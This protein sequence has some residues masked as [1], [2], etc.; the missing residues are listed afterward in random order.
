MDI[1]SFVNMKYFCDAVRLNSITAAAKNNFV[2][3]SAISQG[4]KKLEISLGCAL[5]SGHPNRFRLTPEGQRA[6]ESMFNI[7]KQTL[8]FQ[9]GFQEI[10]EEAIGD[11]E[12]ICMF[13]FAYTVIPSYLKRFQSS[14]PSTLVNLQYS[15]NP[16]EIK[17]LVMA[18]AVDFGILP[19]FDYNESDTSR[20]EKRIIYKT[21]TELFVSGKVREEKQKELKFIITEDLEKAVLFEQ[22][23]E[24]KYGKKPAI[25]LKLPSWVLA[26]RLASEGLG[27]AYLPSFIACQEFYDLQPYK[28]DIKLPAIEAFAIYPRGMKLRKS[29]ETF[30][31][32]FQDSQKLYPT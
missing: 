12:F 18:G 17:R 11:L 21:K 10:R 1:L 2:T 7:L 14:F 3:Q 32:Y 23:Y 16:H 29:S 26:A 30:L 20:F 4:I 6:F 27:I 28:T 15:G 13:S 22:I 19:S 24:K 9:K 8:E 5:L 31:S 25:F